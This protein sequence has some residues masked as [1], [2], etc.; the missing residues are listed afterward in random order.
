M[1]ELISIELDDCKD[2]MSKAVAHT[3]SELN[4]YPTLGKIAHQR[5]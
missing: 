1:N 2:K 3:E 4:C 5:N